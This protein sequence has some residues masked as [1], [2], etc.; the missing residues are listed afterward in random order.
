MTPQPV[1]TTTPHS[2]T[3]CQDW[4]IIGVSATPT[5]VSDNANAIV[6]QTSK[7]CI[8]VAAKEPI[9]PVSRMLAPTAKE[10][11]ARDQG[12]SFSSGTN[13]TPGAARIPAEASN[14]AKVTAT[15]TQP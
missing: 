13:S 15:T 5:A 1:P 11:V 12:N 8:A 10:I 4:R 7:T 3:S 14:A 2:S 6:R 9:R